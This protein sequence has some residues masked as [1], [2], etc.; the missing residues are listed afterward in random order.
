MKE[1]IPLFK[2]FMSDT[3]GDKVKEVLYSGFIGEGP[4]VVDFEEKLAEFVGNDN[5]LTMN[6][7]T[8]ALQIAY[9]ICLDGEKDGEII[10]SPITCTATNTPIVT[11]GAKVVWADVDPITG[12]ICPDSIEEK[13]TAKTKAIVAVHWGGNPCNM[14]RINE[15]AAKYNLK[16]VEDGAHSFGTIYDGKP[17]GNHSDFVM[18]SFQ[19]IKHLTTVDGGCLITKS[20]ED[21]DR[22]KLLRWYGISREVN[23]KEV[24]DLRCELDVAEAGY[25]A[26]MNDVC[27]TVGIENLK[28]MNWIL[29]Q[30]RN[31]AKFYNEVFSRAPNITTIPELPNSQSAY[32]LYTIHVSNQDE[33]MEKM[34]EDGIMVSK[35]HS[36]NDTHTMF[37]DS[38][39]HLP[40]A[41]KFNSTHIC[42]PVGWWLTEQ[43]REYIAEKAIQYAR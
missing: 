28:H 22:A 17:I 31:N 2:V 29:E 9:H 19:A 10:T 35:V 16:V 37:K 24:K 8:A 20:K 30:H 23:T 32:W 38:F 25:K 12:N 21:Y 14:K 3:A 34:K 40:N 42:I 26:H 7:G 11:N 27:A 36:R 6:S 13:I 5:I 33:F 15:I 4:K 43:E 41:E 1:Q 18:H 39:V